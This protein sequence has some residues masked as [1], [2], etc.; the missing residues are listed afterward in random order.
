[1]MKTDTNLSRRRLL[2]RIPAVVA[3]MAPAAASALSGLPTGD[4]PI[5]AAIEEHKRLNMLFGASFDG[6]QEE[7]DEAGDAE[8]AAFWELFETEPTTVAGL[9]VL[10][11]YLGS[12]R[13]GDGYSFLNWAFQTWGYEDEIDDGEAEWTTMISRVLRKLLAA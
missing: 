11:E 13:Y 3:T 8:T 2:A 1:M 12:S 9:I 4:D 7:T 5:F 6:S 10:F